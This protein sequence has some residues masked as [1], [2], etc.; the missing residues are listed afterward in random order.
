MTELD[1]E[2]ALAEGCPSVESLAAYVDH[3]LSPLKRE[4]VEAHLS[5][6][7]L[8]RKTVALTVKSQTVVPDPAL[9][10]QSD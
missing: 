5:V 3:A 7:V 1:E 2:S 6:C 10:H 8:C 4:A 9:P